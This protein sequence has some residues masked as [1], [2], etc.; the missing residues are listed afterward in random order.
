MHEKVSVASMRDVTPA[1]MAHD[2]V[3]RLW[4]PGIR[5][6]ASRLE[7]VGAIA[8]TIAKVRRADARLVR[9]AVAHASPAEVE[10]TTFLAKEILAQNRRPR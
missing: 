10:L 5:R 4:P 2:I 1:A 7:V 8:D 6:N 9:Q 3:E